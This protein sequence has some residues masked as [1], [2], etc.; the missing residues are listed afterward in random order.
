[1]Y[2]SNGLVD[3]AGDWGVRGPRLDANQVESYFAHLYF[4]CFIIHLTFISGRQTEYQFE[5]P[6]E[7]TFRRPKQ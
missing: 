1:V 5:R 6:L 7:R 3:G 2:K 4:L